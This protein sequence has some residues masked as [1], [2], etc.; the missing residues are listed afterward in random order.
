MKKRNTLIR[1]KMLADWKGLT[2][3]QIVKARSM[4]TGCVILEAPH[5]GTEI[6]KAKY[7]V[8]EVLTED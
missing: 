7:K 1:I 6:G 4:T 5:S 8:L 2:K 3:G